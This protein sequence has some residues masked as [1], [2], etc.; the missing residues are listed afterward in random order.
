MWK[1]R[2]AAAP[3]GPGD[4]A[5]SDPPT[6]NTSEAP[7]ASPGESILDGLS[8]AASGA[9][10]SEELVPAAMEVGRVEHFPVRVV[11][12]DQPHGHEDDAIVCD[13]EESLDPQFEDDSDFEQGPPENSEPEKGDAGM[14][15]EGRSYEEGPPEL[16]PEVLL[17]L[18]GQ[19]KLKELDRLLGMTV[20]KRMQGEH[21]K[22]GK[23]RLQCKYVLDWRF[24]NGWVR[25]ARLVAKEYRF[26]EPSL[27][28]L[29]SPASVASS[30]KLLAC[31]AAG[32]S[33]L[34][35]LSLDITDAYLQVRQRRP[36]YIQTDIGD[37]ELLYN[38]PGQRAGAKDW[39]T[40]LLGILKTK[41]LKSFDGNPALFGKEQNLALNSHV[42]DLQI[43]GLKGVPMQL[44]DALKS[45]GLKVK[46]DGPVSLD[47]GCSHFLKKKFQGIGDAIEVTQD[48]KYAERLQSI[49][50]LEKA[51]GKQNPC[52]TK[53]PPPGE[54]ERLE[55]DDL[56]IY[57]RCTGI[58]MYMC[59]ERPDL[60]YVVKVLSSRSSAPTVSDLGLVRH[61][62]K[63]LSWFSSTT[64]G[65]VTP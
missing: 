21:E 65:C 7:A 9:A 26:L 41:N 43:L 46:I 51:Y 22:E 50:G 2:E 31:L 23:V 45:E 61:V 52:P 16:E 34:E 14:P 3:A 60:Q 59:A 12:D 27:T 10:S 44:A 53:V 54:G 29:Y 19:M 49:L 47:G 57:K 1:Q 58:L 56:H 62:V 32:N 13:E 35:L 37:L 36:T 55:G 11:S 18:D 63:Y 25:R 28:D 8:G 38:L 5:G 17:E 30:H 24:R 64:M 48:T 20:L 42:D 4:E 6:S 40:H 33:S 39:F 15:W